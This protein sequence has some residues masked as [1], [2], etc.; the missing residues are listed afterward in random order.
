MLSIPFSGLKVSKGLLVAA[1]LL[2]NEIKFNTK[3]LATSIQEVTLVAVTVRL[4]KN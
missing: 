4:Q 1:F 2:L 3:L